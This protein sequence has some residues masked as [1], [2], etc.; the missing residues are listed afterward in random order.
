MVCSRCIM[1]VTSELGK[2]GF[3]HP[4]VILGEA[5]LNETITDSQKNEIERHL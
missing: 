1:V 5:K 3:N 4:S 2:L